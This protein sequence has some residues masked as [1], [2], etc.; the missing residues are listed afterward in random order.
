MIQSAAARQVETEVK[1]HDDRYLEFL[2]KT[3]GTTTV[4]LFASVYAVVAIILIGVVLT[5]FTTLS[6]REII[7][8]QEGSASGDSSEAEKV[9]ASVSVIAV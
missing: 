9:D 5:V 8:I 6:S 2:Q 4:P 3:F 7:Y 1:T